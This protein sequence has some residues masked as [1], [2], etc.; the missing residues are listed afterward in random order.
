MIYYE[1]LNPAIYQIQSATVGSYNTFPSTPSMD[2]GDF[3]VFYQSG[4]GVL[5]I[6]EVMSDSF[7]LLNP[8]DFN[9]GQP[10]RNFKIVA[11][12]SQPLSLNDREKRALR[13]YNKVHCLPFTFPAIKS[14]LDSL[15]V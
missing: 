8:N 12:F 7:L 10:V 6:G 1:P 9:Y 5:G 2:I 15:A 3:C 13:P 11:I 4:I 14:T